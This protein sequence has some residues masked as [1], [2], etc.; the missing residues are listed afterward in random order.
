MARKSLSR[1]VLMATLGSAA[2][3]CIVADPPQYEE[4]AR[5]PPI[6][7]LANA[8]PFLFDVILFD[9]NDNQQAN[10]EIHFHVPVRSDDQGDELIAALWVD[11][12]Y[13]GQF[14]TDVWRF[15]PDST[16]DDLSRSIDMDYRVA[17]RPPA[18]SG[19]HQLTI[20]V[21]HESNFNQ[22]IFLPDFAKAAGDIA[23]ATWWMNLDPDPADP[24]TLEQCPNRAEFQR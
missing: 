15:I 13:A 4:P 3:G 21:A 11:Y 23:F 2:G 8:Q 6:L 22:E 12:G 16:F 10:D 19:C 5:T 14:F 20:F 17:D 9:R 24:Y 7:D 1:L 18:R